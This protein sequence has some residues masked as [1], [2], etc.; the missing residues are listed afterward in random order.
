MKPSTDVFYVGVSGF[1]YPRWRG[2][3][4]PKEA[5][6]EE[7]LAHYARRLKSVEINSSFYAA[8]KPAAVKGWADK[9]GEEFRFSFKAPQQITHILKLGGGSAEAAN[10]LSETLDLMGPRRGPVLFQLPPYMKQDLKLLEEF[11][12]ETSGI[13]RR[14]FEFRHKSW[15][16]GP[17]YRL[18]DGQATG[19]CIAETEEMRPTFKVTGSFAYLRLRLDSYDAGA[20]DRWAETIGGLE[21][22][23]ECYVY[24][25]HDETGEN[26]LL[27]ERLAKRLK[28]SA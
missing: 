6:S 21:G 1:S 3:F 18:L 23:E 4:Y 9:T 27:A 16:D 10:R 17:T 25:R 8:P 22:S 2:K 11:L 19:F 15:L 20:M 12:D 24:L 14:V 5:K 13:E 7:L 26:A 28:G